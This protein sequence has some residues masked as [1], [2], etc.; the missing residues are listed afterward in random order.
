MSLISYVG[1]IR[2]PEGGGLHAEKSEGVTWR[3]LTKKSGEVDGCA[4]PN[5][6]CTPPMTKE[7]ERSQQVGLYCCIKDPGA[8]Q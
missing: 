1:L 5:F 4:T 6:R 3:S 7:S 8:R 2:G